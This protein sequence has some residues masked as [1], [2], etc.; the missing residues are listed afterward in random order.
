MFESIQFELVKG[1]KANNKGSFVIDPVKRDCDK[2]SKED[3]L[4]EVIV[5]Q[6]DPFNWIDH[7]LGGLRVCKECLLDN[8]KK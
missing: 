5:V 7:P 6:N 8:N 4:T 2:C 1:L 3:F